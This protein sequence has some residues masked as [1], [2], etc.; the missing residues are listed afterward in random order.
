MTDSERLP[1]LFLDVDGP[2]IPF[3]AEAQQYPTYATGLD[4]CA[5]DANP[6]LTRINPEH[7]RKLDALPCEVLTSR[8]GDHVSE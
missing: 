3:G 7:G 8:R 1:L 4:L 2:L 6:L 5:A